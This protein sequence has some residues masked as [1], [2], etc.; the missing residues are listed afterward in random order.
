V[1]NFAAATGKRNSLTDPL[2][3]RLIRFKLQRINTQQQ[4]IKKLRDELYKQKEIQKEYAWEYY[5]M[6]NECITKAK[7][8]NAA[9]RN[10]D[11][12]LKLC[13]DFTDAWIRKGVTLLDLKD[14]YTA[15]TCLNEAVWLSPASF[16]ARY[17]RGKC[18]I[19]L[20]HY[21]EAVADLEKATTM[22]PEY[23]STHEYLAEAY[24]CLGENELARRHQE[25]A[26]KLRDKK[27]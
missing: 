26:G 23:A 4:Q 9:I 11:K 14:Y 22:K 17:N 5:L 15:Q 20:K 12:A 19:L 1:E 16:K 18:H 25:I 13:P 8:H 10:F 3:Q 21:E 27:G 7:D 6:G 2:V 24:R